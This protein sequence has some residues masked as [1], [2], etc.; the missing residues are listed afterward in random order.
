MRGGGE[1]QIRVTTGWADDLVRRQDGENDRGDGKQDGRRRG[2]GGLIFVHIN[3]RRILGP[4]WSMS[5]VGTPPPH[6][7]DKPPRLVES[8]NNNNNVKNNRKNDN[9]NHNF[10]KDGGGDHKQKQQIVLVKIIFQNKQTPHCQ[11]ILQKQY[12]NIL[13]LIKM[14]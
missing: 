7:L 9:S 4:E 2:R 13:L 8:I 12:K 10:D 14:I 1:G 3:K 6:N 5:K 11:M